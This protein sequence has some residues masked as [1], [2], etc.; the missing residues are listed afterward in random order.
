MKFLI[1]TRKVKKN[2]VRLWICIR[3]LH[4]FFIDIWSILNIASYNA[5]SFSDEPDIYILCSS[6]TFVETQ[7]LMQSEL[8]ECF[9]HLAVVT[10]SPLPTVF[11]LA[12]F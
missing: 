10:T 2:V 1:W 3:I 8:Y 7:S 5:N 6:I 4:F 12:E 11:F 9:L